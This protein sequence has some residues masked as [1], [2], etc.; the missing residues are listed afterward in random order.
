MM[1]VMMM[2]NW[3]DDNDLVSDECNGV[4]DIAGSS[5]RSLKTF[6]CGLVAIETDSY[7]HAVA[8]IHASI[9]NMP[10]VLLNERLIVWSD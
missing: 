4:H 8:H 10:H 7:H 1:M 2:I 3:Y 5:H 9:S 6:V